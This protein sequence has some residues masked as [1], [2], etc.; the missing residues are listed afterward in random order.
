MG[1]SEVVR[2]SAVQ[3]GAKKKDALSDM[4]RNK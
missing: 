2:A 3:S 4:F 1:S